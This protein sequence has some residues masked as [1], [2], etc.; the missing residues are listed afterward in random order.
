MGGWIGTV[1]V[2]SM[3]VLIEVNSPSNILEWAIRVHDF[4]IILLYY[5]HYR[6]EWSL[7]HNGNSLGD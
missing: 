5:R 7:K 1:M 3:A 2:V 6:I 4:Q